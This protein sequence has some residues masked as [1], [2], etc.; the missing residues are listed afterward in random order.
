MQH[1]GQQTTGELCL[2]TLWWGDI[3]FLSCPFVRSSETTEQ[4]FMKLVYYMVL[5]LTLQDNMESLLQMLV[6]LL[7][8][9][10]LNI[11][12]CSA[13]ILSNMTCNNQRNKVIVAQ[14]GGIEAL[15]RTILQAGDREDIT[16]PAVSGIFIIFFI[17]KKKNFCYSKV[18]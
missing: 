8:S 6:Q 10:D 7:S 13:G 16:E 1:K 3:L 17:K 15:V 9:N 4:N 2:P 5:Y 12:T 11:V 18:Q 14:V